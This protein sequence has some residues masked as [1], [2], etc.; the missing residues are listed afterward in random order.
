MKTIS[1]LVKCLLALLI[2]LSIVFA[3]AVTAVATAILLIAIMYKDCAIY[4]SLDSGTVLIV[5]HAFT[6]A[7]WYSVTRPISDVINTT[8][9]KLSRWL[10][11]KDY[12]QV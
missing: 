4:E 7:I 5:I 8:D 9:S 1:K 11:M 12:E 6:P 3:L 10:I 2:L